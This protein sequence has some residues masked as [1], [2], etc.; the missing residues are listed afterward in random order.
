[1]GISWRCILTMILCVL[2]STMSTTAQEVSH[3]PTLKIGS[4]G[5]V[6][7]I[8]GIATDAAGKLAVTVGDDGTARVWSLPGL[9]QL[10]V[11]RQA[12]LNMDP[13]ARA[14]ESVKEGPLKTDADVVAVSP[15]GTLAAVASYNGLSYL[16]ETATGRIVRELTH[17]G[18]GFISS[19]AF[20]PD[21]R[22]LAIGRFESARDLVIESVDDGRV[23][24]DHFQQYSDGINVLAF[25]KD[26]RLATVGLDFVMVYDTNGKVLNSQPRSHRGYARDME[27]SPD[28]RQLAIISEF[29][30]PIEI[31]DGATLL[32]A[33]HPEQS[34][35][36]GFIPSIAWS[37]DGQ[38]L[39]AGGVH[40]FKS[41]P[42][43]YPGDQSDVFA[44]SQRGAGARFKAFSA[45]SPQAFLKALPN[46]SFLISPFYEGLELYGP[47]G[48]LLA[49]Q[50]GLS[51]ELGSRAGQDFLVSRDGGVVA[52]SPLGKA[53]E[54]YQ[55][56]ASS[57][58]LTSVTQPRSD[59]VDAR[60]HDEDIAITDWG[61]PKKNAKLNASPLA[62]ELGPLAVDRAAVSNGKVL[63]Q[64]EGGLYL[65]DHAGRRLWLQGG[66]EYPSPYRINL[67]PDGRLALAAGEDGAIRWFRISDGKLLLTLFVTSRGDRWVAFTASGYYQASTDGED[68]FGWQISR[69]RTEA[70]DFY[71]ASRFRDRFSRP[72]VVRRVLSTL[73]E[74]T[75]VRS[76]NA[77][78]QRSEPKATIA[79]ITASLPPVLDLLS[80]PVRF[81]TDSITIRYRVREP[82]G[83]PMIGQPRVKVD[84]DWQPQSR[85]IRR[86][87][88][89]GERSLLVSGLPPHD[90]TI[91]LYAENRNATSPPLAVPLKWDGKADLSQGIQGAAAEHKPRLF[92]LAVGVSQYHRPELNLNFADN[93]ADQFGRA[94]QA[95]QGKEYAEVVS[96]VLLNGDA[97]QSSVRTGLQWL[98]SQVTGDDVGIL[99]MAG[100]GFQMGDEGYFFAAADFDPSRARETGVDY[101]TIRQSLVHFARAGNRAIFLIDTC[102]A[103]GVIGSNLGASSGATLAA[104]LG[105]PENGVVV[106]TAA[107]PNQLSFEDAKWRDG[108]F[109]KA[110]LEAIVDAKAD[111]EESGTITMLD[112]GRYVSKRVPVLTEQRQAPIL[113]M[114]AGGV[115]DFPV[116]A[117]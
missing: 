111:P 73:D 104:E 60:S 58:R 31:R 79:D 62:D 1:M 6:G 56:D 33:L 67:S 57:L 15:D 107:G 68:L 82:E 85:E 64:N 65:L 25:A 46:G 69:G 108:A 84:G 50:P 18:T 114:P 2:A 96:R 88:P 106:L 80:A 112:L 87:D 43:L 44:W 95:Q 24:L 89:G 93:D 59:L 76:A 17:V 74:D 97:T 14:T 16:F 77:E 116:A 92:L 78:S 4:D 28:G 27:F 38:T 105:R 100:H 94:M 22:R 83:A 36:S 41:D 39:L 26:G 99:F 63:V 21:G 23:L 98:E 20:S 11:V 52:W 86:E 40:N 66:A 110:V 115:A 32:P 113:M 54:W 13:S 101:K 103:G 90:L 8:N 49:R 10:R 72:D 70:A 3:L 34:D 29:K 45:R 12:V 42:S 117:R 19:L 48:S 55:F 7:R 61:D 37:R 30:D 5:H 9:K 47:D 71:P 75:A 53:H 51:M 91:E 35:L 102:H 81:N 109:T